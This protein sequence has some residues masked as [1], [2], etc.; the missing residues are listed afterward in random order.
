MFYTR[1][2][3]PKST[4]FSPENLNKATRYFPLIGIIVGSVGALAFIAALQLL[5]VYIATLISIVSMIFLTGAFHEDALADF[6]DGYGGGYTKE[7]ILAIMKDSRIG[8]YGAAGLVLLLLAKLLL[9]A[10]FNP[11]QIPLILIAAHALS[12]VNP[13]ILIF[14]SNYV[15]DENTSKSKPIGQKSSTTTLI[16]ALI[17]GMLPLILISPLIIPFLILVQALLFIYFRHFIQKKTEGYT[18]DVLG[19]LQ[20]LSEVGFYLTYLIVSQ[21]L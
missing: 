13:V 9:I 14:T 7:K 21:L 6:F 19:A 1:I 10:E 8:T 4:G 15:G 12:R 5:S 20:Q 3:V 16:V 17:F 18:G 11:S 2:P